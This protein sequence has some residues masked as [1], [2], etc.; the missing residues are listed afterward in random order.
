[1]KSGRYTIHELFCEGDVGYFCIPEIQRDY[2]WG[3][4]QVTPFV[5]SIVN[6]IKKE[7]P[8]IPKGIPE[9]HKKQYQEFLA[10]LT[11][12]NIGFIYAYFDQSIP[13]RF[14]LVDGQ[15]R[16]TTLYLVLAVLAAKD[17]KCREIFKSRYFRSESRGGSFMAN[18]FRSCQLKVDYKV[19]E[20]SHTVLQHLI[21]DLL[22]AEECQKE[23]VR[24]ILA[25]N[26]KWE[27][28]RQHF[29]AWWQRRFADDL[30]VRS[31][32][33]NSSCIAR[34]ITERCGI[35]PLEMFTWIEEGVEVW[36][37]D[38]ALSQQGEE[39][40]VYMNSRGE[41]LNYN[42]NRRAA[43]LSLCETSEKRNQ[44]S[45]DWDNLLQNRYWAQRGDNPS[46]DK[47]L[48]M[49]LHTVE[50]MVRPKNSTAKRKGEAGEIWK[51]F[52]ENGEC[53]SV[54]PTVDI[55][56][57]YFAYQKAV[58]TLVRQSGQP[59]F[60]CADIFDR[61]A[62]GRWKD[63]ALTQIQ[64]IPYL[65]CLEL[66][67][68]RAI[69]QG[70]DWQKFLN[71]SLFLRNIWRHDEV[72][73]NPGAFIDDFI[74]LARFCRENSLNVLSL[75]NGDNRLLK[76][77][78]KWRLELLKGRFE[79]F[80]VADLAATLA[81]LDE[82]SEPSRG[83]LDVL[84]GVSAVLFATAFD[85]TE[86]EILEQC[87]TMEFDVME[88][89]LKD[90]KARFDRH[91]MTTAIANTIRV[92]LLGGD[93]F[94]SK[95]TGLWYP[96]ILGS[97][98][99]TK[100]WIPHW[101]KRLS[102]PKP[103]A[104][105]TEYQRVNGL[106]VDFLKRDASQPDKAVVPDKFELLQRIACNESAWQN[107]IT[108]LDLESWR[109]G[110]FRANGSKPWKPEF[111]GGNG[112]SLLRFLTEA[113]RTKGLYRE[114]LHL[115]ID[116]DKTIGD[117]MNVTVRV[118]DENDHEIELST[119][120][121]RQEGDWEQTELDKVIDNFQKFGKLNSPKLDVAKEESGIP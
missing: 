71:C 90:A 74:S 89:K 33:A 103:S 116:Y 70:D 60:S 106:V 56:N 8:D 39:L 13:N 52:Y 43:C 38:T 19:R 30:T 29:P 75:L 36:Y 10:Q 27:G 44:L 121:F 66:L 101:C 96:F 99:E 25:G 28:E 58:E 118:L 4:E 105:G 111:K 94:E 21:F 59:A 50:M 86:D 77:E 40:Y 49:F 112:T 100:N 1:M 61:F 12:Y 47:G 20:T 24:E 95:G 107:F 85:G 108:V 67:K 32:F 80:G 87:K 109:E 45:L 88:S 9:S 76:D 115:S 46:A 7:T 23:F 81:L 79:K 2:V 69:D 72:E 93:V 110:R 18:D 15:Q 37:F 17:E 34:L 83:V 51:K 104:S 42:E 11:R 53:P 65:A 55:L 26:W 82:I 5:Q 98:M 97:K 78:E 41:Q 62:A 54:P 119:I 16:L 63:A 22:S 64:V 102:S 120:P 3:E 114:K 48:D 73:R 57:D 92:L 68:G 113:W 14:F 35:D 6:S 84:K 117:E 91:F 31:L